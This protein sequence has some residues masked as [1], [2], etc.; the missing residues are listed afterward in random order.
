[1]EGRGKGTKAAVA[2]LRSWK[3]Y[4][5]GVQRRHTRGG[6]TQGLHTPIPSPAPSPACHPFCG[7]GR[8][9]LELTPESSEG[10]AG[11]LKP[12]GTRL[13]GPRGAGDTLVL[14]ARCTGATPPGLGYQSTPMAGHHAAARG[15][16]SLMLG[17]P[18]TL[19]RMST[20]FC[21]ASR[22]SCTSSELK[23]PPPVTSMIFTAYSWLVGLW[24]QRLTTLLTPLGVQRTDHP[25]GPRARP[26]S[27]LQHICPALSP[28]SL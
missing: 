23:L 1:M 18:E 15:R 27:R 7:A 8:G 14:L 26:R 6:G 24:M 9:G 11:S 5:D 25:R 12:L 21:V 28:N 3:G 22:S 19:R 17:C 4:R 20:S 2:G 13:S 16:H 10:G